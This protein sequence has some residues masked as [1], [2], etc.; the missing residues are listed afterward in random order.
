[1]DDEK[2]LSFIRTKQNEALATGSGTSADWAA[3]DVWRDLE[4]IA[5]EFSKSCDDIA[6]E[7]P[8][9][10][11]VEDELE[12]AQR[13]VDDLEEEVLRWEKINNELMKKLEAIQ[14]IADE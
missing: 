3:Y 4:I 2:L 13:R 10:T 14:E 1:M 6:A 8:S 11:D 5:L 12:D 9:I 7:I